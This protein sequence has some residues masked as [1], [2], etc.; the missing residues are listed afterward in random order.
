MQ[1]IKV[2]RC[3]TVRGFQNS[4]SDLSKNRMHPFVSPESHQD[5]TYEKQNLMIELEFSLGKK[6]GQINKSII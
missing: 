3:H 6:R 1:S 5:Y 2:T 4:E